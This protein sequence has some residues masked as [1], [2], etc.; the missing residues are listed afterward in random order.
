[1]NGGG[2]N[3]NMGVSEPSESNGQ[4]WLSS[5]RLAHGISVVFSSGLQMQLMMQLICW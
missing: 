2:M 5:K 1:M 4:C 3:A